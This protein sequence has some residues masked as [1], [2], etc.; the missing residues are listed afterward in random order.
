MGSQIRA[1]CPCGYKSTFTIGGSM[2]SHLTLSYFPYRCAVCGI[3]STNVAEE[4]PKCPK[5]SSHTV[6]RIGGSFS[7][8]VAAE[9]AA[10]NAKK[11][12]LRTL[13]EW[14]GL[15]KTPPSRG[16]V[17]TPKRETCFSWRDHEIYDEPYECPKCA[18]VRLYFANTGLRFD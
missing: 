4:P 11:R 9:R 17:P 14:L 13:L 16:P 3:V 5:N 7:Q 6:A 10:A 2:K 15:R 18:E 1:T 12:K 8:R